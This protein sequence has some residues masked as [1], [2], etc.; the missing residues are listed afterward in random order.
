A[1]SNAGVQNYAVVALDAMRG[2]PLAV[3]NAGLT[4]YLAM[5]AVG[6]LL[7]GVLAAR[8]GRHAAVASV[9]LVA[10][11]AVLGVVVFDSGD[12][13]MIGLLALAGLTTGL[14]MPARDMLVRAV[15]PPGAFGKVFGFVTTGFNIG[16]AIAPIVFGWMM[17]TGR[18]GWTFV[19]AALF[20]LASIPTVTLS[21]ARPRRP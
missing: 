19:A 14:I 15:T 13:M 9:G 3:A 6:V 10:N 11:A 2:T 5:S 18:P 12:A 21:A 17:D 1:L 4:A 20:S 16:G 8:V 7:G